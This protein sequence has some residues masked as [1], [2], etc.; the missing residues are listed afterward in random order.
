MKKIY[1]FH[2]EKREIIGEEERRRWEI[3]NNNKTISIKCTNIHLL[4][5]KKTN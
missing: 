2:N 5:V 1:Q 3:N 4:Y